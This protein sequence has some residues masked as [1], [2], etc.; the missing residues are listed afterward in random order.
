[1]VIMINFRFTDNSPRDIFAEN[2]NGLLM[3]VWFVEKGYGTIR[4][5]GGGTGK[6]HDFT[7]WI[8][9]MVSYE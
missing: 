8:N 9:L 1:M 5:V 6:V 7:K 3:G 4:L 2:L